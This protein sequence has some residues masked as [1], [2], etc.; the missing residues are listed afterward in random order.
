MLCGRYLHFET[1]LFTSMNLLFALL[2]AAILSLRQ[3][4]GVGTDI[5]Q[6]HVCGPRFLI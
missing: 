6:A 4:L 5:I 1:A 2:H 3:F